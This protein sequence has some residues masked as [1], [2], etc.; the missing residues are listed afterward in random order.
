[1]WSSID[2]FQLGRLDALSL[3]DYASFD[4]LILRWELCRGII[5]GDSGPGAVISHIYGL[6]PRGSDWKSGRRM[7]VLYEGFHGG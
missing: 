5:Q 7:K 1:M 2:Y 4:C 6:E 3:L